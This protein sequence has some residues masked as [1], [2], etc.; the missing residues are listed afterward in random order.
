MGSA[1]HGDGTGAWLRISRETEEKL[2]HV[3]NPVGFIRRIC[4]D[5]MTTL[6]TFI[7]KIGHKTSDRRSK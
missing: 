1:V 5:V 6:I 4:C 2:H 7:K 3:D